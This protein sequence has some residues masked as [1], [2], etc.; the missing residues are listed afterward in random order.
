MLKK[1][2]RMFFDYDIVDSYLEYIG[3]GHW[4]V[5]Y[6]KEWRFKLKRKGGAKC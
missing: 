3:D 6:I 5:K 4:K 2:I 1:F